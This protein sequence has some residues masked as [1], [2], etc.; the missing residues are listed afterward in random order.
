MQVQKCGSSKDKLHVIMCYRTWNWAKASKFFFFLATLRSSSVK[1]S[2]RCSH[3]TCY[4]VQS[5]KRGYR[6]LSLAD[7]YPGECSSHCYICCLVLKN[8][9]LGFFCNIFPSQ[10]CNI[11][12]GKISCIFS[13]LYP[14]F[15]PYVEKFV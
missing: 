5:G 15:L 7:R 8:T 1:S 14:K 2:G 6:G 11:I 9:L 10:L 3:R 12:P 4:Q 13:G